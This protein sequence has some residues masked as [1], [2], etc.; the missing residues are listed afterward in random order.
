MKFY[1]RTTSE[2]WEAIQREGVLWGV[3]MSYRHTYLSPE[4]FDESYGDVLL[5]VLYEPG[6]MKDNYAD[7][8]WQF[9]VFEP[10][11]LSCVKAAQARK[12]NQ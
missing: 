9:T 4:P 10:I 1:H 2:A 5:E 7:G 6:S 3:G 8:C 12:E 11:P